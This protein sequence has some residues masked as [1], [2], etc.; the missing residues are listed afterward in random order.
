MGSLVCFHGFSIHVWQ[1]ERQMREPR[2]EWGPLATVAPIPA[3]YPGHSFL[4]WL[5]FYVWFPNLAF[6]LWAILYLLKLMISIES[7]SESRSVLSNPLWPHSSPRNSPGQNTGVGSLPFS[8]GSSQSRNRT[9]VSCIAGGS[10][11][12]W[13]IRE[14]RYV[15]PNR[16]TILQLTGSFIIFSTS[17]WIL[18]VLWLNPS[19]LFFLLPHSDFVLMPGEKTNHC[20]DWKKFM[21]CNLSHSPS[22]NTWLLSYSPKQLRQFLEILPKAPLH[23][24]LPSSFPSIFGKQRSHLL[25]RE[26][27][28]SRLSCPNSNF[29]DGD[30]CHQ[31]I[32]AILCFS[33]SP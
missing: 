16:F 6:D 20:L 29:M 31:N 26:A 17:P 33:F 12:N 5:L 9:G 11:T 30:S 21:I 25:R 22:K 24:L 19:P 28:I 10:F 15:K 3:G 32:T 18:F 13:A 8:R 7:E 23:H 2:Q 14:A 1:V 27:R 4:G